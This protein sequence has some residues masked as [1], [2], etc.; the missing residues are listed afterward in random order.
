M[1]ALLGLLMLCGWCAVAIGVSTDSGAGG[2]RTVGAV[3]SKRGGSTTIVVGGPFAAAAIVVTNDPEP[4]ADA[5]PADEH[6]DAATTW[7]L[8]VIFGSVAIFDS[9]DG[10]DRSAVADDSYPADGVPTPDVPAAYDAA[11]LLDGVSTPAPLGFDGAGV[12]TEAD[13][14]L[15]DSAALEELWRLP[16]A[17]ADQRAPVTKQA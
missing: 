5:V 8:P 1:L 17:T 7:E 6:S 2:A 14:I 11:M 9:S 3:V 15:A 4:G 13:R 12:I 10:P 16:A